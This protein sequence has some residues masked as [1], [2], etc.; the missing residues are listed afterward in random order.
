VENIIVRYMQIKDALEKK[1]LWDAVNEPIQQIPLEKS[2][3]KF[4]LDVR[5]NPFINI[6]EYVNKS[7]F[8]NTKD[9]VNSM[10]PEYKIQ[11]PS[12]NESTWEHDALQPIVKF[13]T[14]DLED[15]LFVRCKASKRRNGS[16]GPI[17]KNDIFG[18]YKS[19]HYEYEVLLGE[20]SNGPFFNT[21]QVQSHTSDDHDKLGKCGKDSLDDALNYLTSKNLNLKIFKEI[22]IFLIHAHGT[23]LELFVLDQNFEPFFRL[24]RL[25]NISVPYKQGTSDGIIDLVQNLLTFRNM[26][27]CTLNKLKEIDN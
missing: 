23:S 19:N 24:R 10:I 17:K 20:V 22:N 12:I 2:L 15:D 6:P 9:L 18:V 14:H 16:K 7:L 11:S 5:D 8:S 4:I 26:L 25:S 27:T 21:T 1:N 13:I 3:E